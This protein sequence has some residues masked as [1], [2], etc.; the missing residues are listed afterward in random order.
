MDCPAT[1]EDK[2]DGDLVCGG[3]KP[4]Y[5]TDSLEAESCVAV[6]A[7]FKIKGKLIYFII[8]QINSY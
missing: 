7:A 5:T 4:D 6:D 2:A 3:S 1:T 8:Y